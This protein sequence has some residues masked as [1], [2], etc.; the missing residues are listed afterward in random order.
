MLAHSIKGMPW[1]WFDGRVFESV[2]DMVLLLGL[3]VAFV[4]ALRLEPRVREFE[5][6]VV[7]ALGAHPD[8]I[9]LGCAGLIL[10][11][12]A[13]GA[14]V[15]GLTFTRG[16]KGTDRPAERELE[17]RKAAEFLELDGHWILDFPDT[18]LQQKVPAVK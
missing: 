7:L 2:S 5:G 1:G 3:G 12:K 17:T 18:G 10:K 9:E 15:Y 13:S 8:D 16:E 14:R 6:E 11:L 4:T